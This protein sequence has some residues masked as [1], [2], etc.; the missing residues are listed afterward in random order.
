MPEP[1]RY[2]EVSAWFW[3]EMDERRKR[4][5]NF[6]ALITGPP[7]RGK[8]LFGIRL[9]E[10]L[11]HRWGVQISPELPICIYNPLSFWNFMEKSP[12]WTVA[13]WDEPNKGLSHRQ[14]YE[15]MNKAVVTYLQT[16]RFKKKNLLLMLPSARL[17]DKSAR[18]VC[19]FEIMMKEPGL[20]RV[21]QLIQNDFGST[22]EF[23]K[24]FRGE[25]KLNM[26]ERSLVKRNEQEKEEFHSN[27]FPE[28]AFHDAMPVELRGWKRIYAEVKKDLDK[29]RAEKPEVMGQV[30]RLSAR[31]ISALLDCSDNT[32]RKVVTKIEEESRVTA[33]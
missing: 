29:Y 16:F 9:A 1:P 19:A 17:V 18:A 28:E 30:P 2:W 24:Q 21:Y 31:R 6:V 20:G 25:I 11:H 7:G 3:E 4:E 5:K 10:E 14:W 27:D 32:A 26:P 23:W 8:T 22:P 13:K 12:D 15:E 33:T